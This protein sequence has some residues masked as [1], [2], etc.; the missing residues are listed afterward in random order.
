MYITLNYLRTQENT[1]EYVNWQFSIEYN[2]SILWSMK[3]TWA[4]RLQA[5]ELGLALGLCSPE[6]DD[7]K[8]G[9]K[10]RVPGRPEG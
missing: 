3:A 9:L 6:T 2:S 5:W 10:K 8:F 1:A 4:R 7:M